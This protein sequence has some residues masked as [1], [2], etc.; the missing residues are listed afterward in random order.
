MR[1]KTVGQTAPSRR[2]MLWQMSFFPLLISG[3]KIHKRTHRTRANELSA[4]KRR[5][6]R[7]FSGALVDK[8]ML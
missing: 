7:T 2:R 1:S 4:L 8:Q 6:G 5:K 3:R